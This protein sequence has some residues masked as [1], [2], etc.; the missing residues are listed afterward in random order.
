[1]IHCFLLR[2]AEIL[3]LLLS[4][5]K[6]LQNGSCDARRKAAERCLSELEAE[7]RDGERVSLRSP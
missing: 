3:P 6:A 2:E 7:G 4:V 5:L 1:M